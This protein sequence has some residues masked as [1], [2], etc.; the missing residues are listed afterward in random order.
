MCWTTD[1]S[2]AAGTMWMKGM[3]K[4]EFVTTLNKPLHSRTLVHARR[5]LWHYIP[6]LSTLMF[7]SE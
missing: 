6:A 7:G 3:V 4:A 1:Q 5:A 2:I